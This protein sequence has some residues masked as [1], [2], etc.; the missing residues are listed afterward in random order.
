MPLLFAGVLI[1]GAVLSYEANL[2]SGGSGA[3]YLGIG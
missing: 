1:E 3:R 2:E